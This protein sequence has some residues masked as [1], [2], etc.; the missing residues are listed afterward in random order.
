[1]FTVC[2]NY[3]TRKCTVMV[4]Y[5]EFLTLKFVLINEGE[6]N[7]KLPQ[8]FG[9]KNLRITHKKKA[10][11][12]DLVKKKAWHGVLDVCAAVKHKIILP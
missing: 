5:Y 11:Y 1:M 7:R 10:L 3:C 8:M 9:G 2:I 6:S 12:A 4:P